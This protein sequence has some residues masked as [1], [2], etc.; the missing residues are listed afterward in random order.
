VLREQGS[1]R[2]VYF[3]GDIGRAY[4]R[5]QNPDLS[6]LLVN[7]MRWMLKETTPLSVTGEGMAEIFAWKTQPG[8]AVHVLNYNN[9]D[10]LRGW[11]T[12]AYPL[13]AQ[14]V[15]MAL[16]QGVKIS[17]VKLLRAGSDA[18]FSQNE[19]T[20]EFEIPGVTDY[21]VAALV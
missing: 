17:Q 2:T 9:P 15:R 14:K 8:F 20:V 11:F 12:H 10:M 13:G 1:R 18:P 7:S 16:P 19:E 3:P 4:W 6:R 21:E 5:S